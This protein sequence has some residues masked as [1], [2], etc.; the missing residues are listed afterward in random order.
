MSCSVAVAVLTFRMKSAHKNYTG[1]HV[2][3]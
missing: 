2:V 3:E 1:L